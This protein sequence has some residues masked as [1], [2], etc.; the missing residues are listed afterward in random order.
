MQSFEQDASVSAAQYCYASAFTGIRRPSTFCYAFDVTNSTHVE[1]GAAGHGWTECYINDKDPVPGTWGSPAELFG[2]LDSRIAEIL[3]VYCGK[4]WD[5]VSCAEPKAVNNLLKSY[6][7][8][9]LSNIAIVTVWVSDGTLAAPCPSCSKWVYKTL[10]SVNKQN[11]MGDV[12]GA[13]GPRQNS[14]GSEEDDY[15]GTRIQL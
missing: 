12:S 7:S 14:F 5:A 9:K 15:E 1:T 11:S 2:E 4:R 10:H 13:L 8:T 3:E 6:P